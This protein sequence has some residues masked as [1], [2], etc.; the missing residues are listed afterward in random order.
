MKSYRIPVLW[1]LLLCV[2]GALFAQASS[3][4]DVAA[5]KQFLVSHQ[6]LTPEQFR[7]LYATGTFAAKTPT[8][9]AT[10]RYF[11]SIDARHNLT[12]YEKSLIIEHGFM[13]TEQLQRGSCGN[14]FAEIYN[15][16]LPVFVSTDAILH[17]LHMWWDRILM[18]VEM[19][20]LRKKL[21]TLLARLHGQVP[22]LATK[23]S[24]S[25][26]MTQMINDVD[27][28]HLT[29]GNQRQIGKMSFVK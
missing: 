16:D 22:A 11:D 26:A 14:A 12:A 24:S 21:G 15:R 19:A 29:I 2:Y 4:F 13:A 1:A 6:N 10:A 20:I 7:T 23:Y 9:P 25:P 17:S 18:D 8:S 3:S 5:Y 27:V 28:Y